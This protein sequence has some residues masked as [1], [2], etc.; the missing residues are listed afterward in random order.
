MNSR[1]EPVLYAARTLPPAELPRLLGDLEEVKAVAFSRLN[2]PALAPVAPDELLSVRQAAQKL[3]C[4]T[5]YLYR[6]ELPFIIRMGRKR[7]FSQ[8]GIEAY[9]R[10]QK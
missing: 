9:L 1:L 4:S 5:A 10:K 3:G 7:M 6:N 2:A 8:N